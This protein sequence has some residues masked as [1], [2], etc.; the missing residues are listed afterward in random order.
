VIDSAAV[1][2]TAS[3]H[4]SMMTTLVELR[5]VLRADHDALVAEF[6]E[7]KVDYNNPLQRVEGAVRTARVPWSDIQ[8]LSYRR[9]WWF[10][11]GKIVLR[12]RGLHALEALPNAEGNEVVLRVRRADHAVAREMVS[13]VELAR[14][15]ARL[16]GLEADELR[17][18]PG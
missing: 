16:R 8:S 5:G 4:G 7:T 9:G 14:A 18:P 2:F 10:R 3:Y 6:R 13:L 12:T 15:E 17:L 11:P 1:P